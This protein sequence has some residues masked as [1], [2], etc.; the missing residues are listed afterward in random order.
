MRNLILEEREY[1]YLK[2]TGK[3]LIVR[4]NNFVEGLR[5]A[6]CPWN[7]KSIIVKVR[8]LGGFCRKNFEAFWEHTGFESPDKYLEYLK[9]KFGNFVFRERSY[10]F[11]VCKVVKGDVAKTLAENLRDASYSLS[12]LTEAFL[13]KEITRDNFL[14]SANEEYKKLRK[15]ILDLKQLENPAEGL[16]GN[17]EDANGE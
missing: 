5:M 9:T 13:Y 4:D 11:F 2:R 14:A 17:D 12:A 15:I 16:G 7:G 1:D 10:S 6:Y 3:L 8:R